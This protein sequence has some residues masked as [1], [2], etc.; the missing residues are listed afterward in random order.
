MSTYYKH[1]ESV[2]KYAQRSPDQLFNVAVM[3]LLSIRQQWST[4]GEQ[5]RDVEK[6]GEDS[7]YLFGFKKTG[8][9]YLKRNIDWLYT[10]TTTATSD[11][12]LLD[13]W[14]TVPGLGLVKA[15]FV[16]QLARGVGGCIDLHNM[17]EYGIPAAQLRYDKGLSVKA[18][19][20]KLRGDLTLCEELGG[21]LHLWTQWCVIIAGKQ[22]QH[23]SSPQA[24]SRSHLQYLGIRCLLK[25]EET[26]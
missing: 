5:M 9:R 15:G 17:K 13:A 8:Y 26:T 14:S 2:N 25:R 18:R 22:G 4:I 16:L 12:E 19:A 7:K 24:V 10:V 3:V 21:S 11:Y 6:H 23:F 1:I 20:I